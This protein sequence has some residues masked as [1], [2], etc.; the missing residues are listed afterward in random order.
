VGAAISGAGSVPRPIPTTALLGLVLGFA[1]VWN[2]V[3]NLVLPGA[4]YVPGN[5]AGAALLVGLAR[6]F[7]LG[8]GDL[9]LAR[10]RIPRGLVI[11]LGAAVLVAVVLGI[12]LVIPAAESALEDD[13]VRADTTFDRWFVPLV[14]IPLGTAVFEEVLFRSVLLGVLLTRHST[15]WAVAISS[16]LFGLWHVVPAWEGAGDGAAAVLGAV[17]GTVAVTAVAGLLFAALLLWSRSVVAPILAHTATNS[18]AYAAAL[19]ALE[20]VE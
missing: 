5:L 18:L 2:L 14:R 13:G 20:V 11:G 12:G 1:V 4:W 15:R 16:A 6:R 19:I 7:G 10:D 9:G 8:W 3:G 17:A